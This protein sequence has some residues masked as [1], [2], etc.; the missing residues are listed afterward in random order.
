VVRIADR[1]VELG[2]V[3]T[4]VPDPAGQLVHPLEDERCPQPG[5]SVPRCRL[6]GPLRA[7]AH[8]KV[9]ADRL[10]HSSPTVTMKVYAHI[11]PSL[12]ERVTSGLEEIFRRGRAE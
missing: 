6:R 8:A 9:I 5:L 2:Q 4:L 1:R 11:L 12:G 3:I 7:G 10:G